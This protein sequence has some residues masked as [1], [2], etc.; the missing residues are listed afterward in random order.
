MMA[1]KNKLPVRLLALSDNNK[2]QRA[3]RLVEVNDCHSNK[4]R[5]LLIAATDVMDKR[6]LLEKLTDAGLSLD[7]TDSDFKEIV[8]HLKSVSSERVKLCMRPGYINVGGSLCYLSGSGKVFGEYEGCAPMPYPD[9]NTFTCEESQK[10]TLKQWQKHVASVAIHSP[11]A[12]LALCSAMAGYCIYF[13]D[14]ESGGFHFYGDS[15]KGKSTVLL[16][17]A[18]VYGNDSFVCDWNI[19]ETAFE[20]LAE[21]RNHGML[22][23][24]ELILL[25]KNA[26]EAAQKAR[27][28]I[29]ILGSG[30]GKQRSVNFQQHKSLW[31]LTAISNG[32]NG[33][34]QHAADGDMP[35]KKGE[36]ARFVDVP[37]DCGNEL[38]IF[39][40]VP[41]NAAPSDY[42]ERIK[43]SCQR[44]HGTAGP[45]LV[46]TLLKKS[47]GFLADK[48]D[49]YVQ[50]FL[51]QHNIEGLNGL[52]KRIAKRFALAYASG[53]I[54]VKCKIL[55]FKLQ[56]VMEGISY[57][58]M[59]ACDKTPQKKEV[60]TQVLKKALKEN[61]YP[62][63]ADTLDIET[64][65]EVNVIATTI[66]GV[67]V[68]AVKAD[69]FKANI[70]G[71]LKQITALLIKQDRLFVD[72]DG[73]S[74]RQ[75]SRGG[76]R[77]KRRYC[78]KV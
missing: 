46:T 8:D 56:E 10:G 48:I 38:G 28:L 51:K 75:I 67:D 7:F 35:R 57:C 52:E 66:G 20:E 64:L 16:I 62:L 17:A 60:F 71:D 76:Q 41:D 25:D 13:T 39:L 15:S 24:D 27:K 23:L 77:L 26:K 30:G 31:Q 73:K 14:F 70:N 68:L 40:T 78:L 45:A 21:S 19:T 50:M 61:A 37:V 59:Q 42:A 65:N 2:L 32:E 69:F 29:Y 33:L 49:E 12:M 55:P 4:W 34:A 58:Y 18:S 43:A 47:S 63:P 5:Q 22:I 1:K 44:Y 9:A 72:T 36:M 3:Y 74:T 54:A 6:K 11:Y 53:A